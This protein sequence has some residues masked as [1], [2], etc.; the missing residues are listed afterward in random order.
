MKVEEDRKD[1][2]L[3]R[4]NKKESFRGPRFAVGGDAIEKRIMTRFP[5]KHVAVS[6]E[7]LSKTISGRMRMSRLCDAFPTRRLS[8]A[9]CRVG[10]ASSIRHGE[11]DPAGFWAN[12]GP[13]PVRSPSSLANFYSLGTASN[14]PGNAFAEKD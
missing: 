11:A 10:A 14:R 3:A 7:K 6:R 4:N 1:R 12:V 9:A 2:E 8:K 5:S 13:Q